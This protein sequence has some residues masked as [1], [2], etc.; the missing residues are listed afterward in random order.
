VL[1]LWA[2]SAKRGEFL[3]SGM[4]VW[5]ARLAGGITRQVSWQALKEASGSHQL[6]DGRADL[7]A[8]LL[9]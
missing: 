2:T 4:K 8:Q 5:Q 7:L 6:C 1:K 9:C 3:K